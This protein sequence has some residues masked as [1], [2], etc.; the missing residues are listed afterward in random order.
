LVRTLNA[1]DEVEIAY[2]EPMPEV[3]EDID[4]PT[5]DYQPNQD[6]REAAPD[7]VD[8]DYANSLPGGD[9]SGIKIIDIEINWQTTHEDIDKAL[10]AVIGPYPGEGQTSTNH[11]TAVL[12]EMVAGNNGYGMTGIC[13]GA[14]VAM[15]SISTMSTAQALRFDPD[16]TAYTWTSLQ[17]SVATGPTRIC[18]HGVLAGQL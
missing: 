6:Y 8:A 4:P 10:G 17:L 14:D 9:G 3:A 15:V 5:P 2:V 7:G 18:V 16:R 13:Y 11:G 12:G 1:L